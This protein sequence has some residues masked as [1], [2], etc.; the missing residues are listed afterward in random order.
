MGFGS[1]FTSASDITPVNVANAINNERSQRHIPTLNYSSKLAAAAQY[2]A[3]DMVAR[4][5]FAHVDPD[6]HYIWDK[7][8]AEGYT[9]FTI[10]GENLAVDFSDTEGLVSAWMDSPTHRENIL[11]ASFADQG[12]GV[13]FGN[14]A[15]AEFSVAVANT[16]GAQPAHAAATPP[17]APTP[18]PAPAPKPA[19]TPKPA[20]APAPTPAAPQPAPSPLPIPKPTPGNIPSIALG[21]STPIIYS[22][23][24]QL[25][26]QTVPDVSVQISDLTQPRAVPVNVQTDN[27]G[28]FAYT[29]NSL[30]NGVHKFQAQ[31]QTA[32]KTL[33]SNIYSVEILYN[34]PVIN[35][36]GTVVTAKIVNS[37]LDLHVTAPISGEVAGANAAINGQSASLAEGPNGIFSGDL[38]TDQ[39]FDY[40]SQP[41]VLSAQNVHQN[42]ASAAISLS[43]VALLSPNPKSLTGNLAEKARNADLYNVFKYVVI[44]FGSLFILFLLID[45][46]RY[47]KNKITGAF[48]AG[49]G[50]ILILILIGTTLI[51]SWWH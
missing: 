41:L 17:P 25:F 50:S 38:V 9:P 37:K 31:T 49:N 14:P 51:A 39:Y 34:P 45:L 15:N 5:Y 47:G 18:K 48:S 35:Q 12:V 29:V 19:P 33:S 46:L 7:I 1:F 20:P 42:S 23:S 8:M 44:V 2:K 6:G 26:G 21:N 28:Q 32:G 13:D 16:F 11:N 22:N 27:N 40:Q 30:P 43:K 10:L 24:I 36:A 4:K 3:N